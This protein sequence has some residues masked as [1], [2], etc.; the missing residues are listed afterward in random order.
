MRFT[1]KLYL[2]FVHILDRLK[3]AAEAEAEASQEMEDLPRIVDQIREVYSTFVPG[4]ALGALT[5]MAHE[6]YEQVFS[7]GSR[8]CFT[9]A[10]KIAVDVEIIEP[11]IMNGELMYRV[12][13]ESPP[14]KAPL[15]RWVPALACEP[16]ADADAW[17]YVW[18]NRETETYE[19]PP[20]EA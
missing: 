10:G 6:G 2:Q 9:Q 19:D 1:E 17:D 11:T 20:D 13:A 15:R 3:V 14:G 12:I 7:E 4:T 16:S 5:D 8:V 18:W